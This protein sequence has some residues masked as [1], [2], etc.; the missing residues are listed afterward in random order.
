MGEREFKLAEME[1]VF[2]Q[3]EW[4]ID[5]PPLIAAKLDERILQEIY[6][7]RVETLA[8]VAELEIQTKQIQRDMY[9][10]VAKA[11]GK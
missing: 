4:V 6:R 2:L 5:P 9:R 1:S 7:I 3:K 10:Q 8:Q 11:L